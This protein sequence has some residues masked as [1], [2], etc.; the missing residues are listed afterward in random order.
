[1]WF[2]LQFMIYLLW[3]LYDRNGRK[4]PKYNK[5]EK[6]NRGKKFPVWLSS[7]PPVY[8]VEADFFLMS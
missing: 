6:R 3:M 7:Y 4:T 1:M 5:N 2:Y 8:E